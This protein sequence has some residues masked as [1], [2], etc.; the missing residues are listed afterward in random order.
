[1][2]K[3]LM[4]LL[5]LCICIWSCKKNEDVN[6][7]L[8]DQPGTQTMLNAASTHLPLTVVTIA[9]K[10]N[11]GITFDFPHG[12]DVADDGSIY[13]AEQNAHRIRKISPNNTVTTVAIPNASNGQPLHSPTRVRV[14]KDGTINILAIN[15]PHVVGLHAVWIVKPNGQVLTP[16]F[17]PG[18]PGPDGRAY[19]Y[20]DLQIDGRN[21]E[22]FI[23]GENLKIGLGSI[24]KFKVS[25]Q[26]YIGTDELNVQKDSVFQDPNIGLSPIIRAFFCGYNGVK[27]IVLNYK[28]IY[29]LTPSGVFTRIFRNL[30]FNNI[31]CLVANK[32]SRSIY[33][34]DDLAIKVISNNQVHYITGPSRR[35]DAHD[36][37]GTSADVRAVQIALSKDEGTLYFTDTRSLIRKIL[38]R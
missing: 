19:I 28:Y 20:E 1:M 24:Q 4:L 35:P 22:V 15:T 36:G 16:P 26:G 34:V 33:I 8:N 23:S 27:Y 21:D 6:A 9:G 3:Q 7:G 29:K 5:V 18:G 31:H 10:P 11:S 2:K 37:V 14:Q 30:T 17:A 38:L 25:P 13:I 12:I 32:D